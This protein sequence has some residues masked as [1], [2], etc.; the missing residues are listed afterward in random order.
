MKL[1][2][3]DLG[4]VLFQ[5]D[6]KEALVFL[7]HKTG[8]SP[9]ILRKRVSIGAEFE[10]FERGE[11]SEASF[12][13]WLAGQLDAN[14]ATETLIQ[15]WNAIYGPVFLP[16]YESIRKLS[17][18]M[19]VVAL[20]N[21]NAT[22][23]PVWQTLYE[24]ELGIFHKIYVSSELGMRKPEKR[25]Y[26]HVMEEWEVSPEET[27]FFDDLHENINAAAE[28]GLATALVDS[29]AVV[30]KWVETYLF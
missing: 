25:I 23:Q 16:T 15:G 13:V 17:A 27:I 29:D 21:T 5:I 7:A 9:R 22:H 10:A 20:T 18:H 14:I 28:I 2:I 3:F 30:A 6:F 8:L 24:K 11:L 19:P 26:R 12:F 4:N 1:A